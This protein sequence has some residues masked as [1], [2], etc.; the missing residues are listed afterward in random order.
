[1]V[2]AMLVQLPTLPLTAHGKVDRRA[3]PEPE[4]CDS[5]EKI[6]PAGPRGVIEEILANIWADV[7]GTEQVQPKH[8]FFDLGGHSLLAPRAISRIRAALGVERPRRVQI[9]R[10]TLA[11][12]AEH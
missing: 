1:M 2:P 4:E 9:E 6:C 7:L 12:L 8:N 3:L 10:Y 11:D 5:E